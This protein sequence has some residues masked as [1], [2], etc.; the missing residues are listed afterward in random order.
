[1]NISAP[2]IKRPVMT[3]LL[4]LAICVAGWIA[5]RALPVSDLPNIENP[6]VMVTT[7]YPGASPDVVLREITIPIEKALH[8]VKGIKE[9]ISVSNQGKSLIT[10][11][12][13]TNKNME[14]TI[15]DLQAALHHV[16]DKLPKNLPT[17]PQYFRETRSNMPIFSF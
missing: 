13:A 16:E 11:T 15:R 12:F 17:K 10:M 7:E 14:E 3:T 6:R 1:M 9:L 4:S 5:F 8:E 2:F